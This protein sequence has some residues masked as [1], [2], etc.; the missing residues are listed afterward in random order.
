[1][2]RRPTIS[3]KRQF[4]KLEEVTVGKS[5]EGISLCKQRI[6]DRTGHG[7][8]KRKP[9]KDV[10]QFS[11]KNIVERH[12]EEQPLSMSASTSSPG[13]LDDTG[14]HPNLSRAF[15]FGDLEIPV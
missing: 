5:A 12:H 14:E 2:A 11:G 6:N 15:T 4:T 10:H 8:V 1:M 13:R 9:I 3:E 7:N